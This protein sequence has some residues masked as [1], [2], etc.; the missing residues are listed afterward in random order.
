MVSLPPS[1]PMLTVK[2][3][4]NKFWG[5]M[6]S[7][8]DQSAG[9]V[10]QCKADVL[11]QQILEARVAASKEIAFL[12][13]EILA[14]LNEDINRPRFDSAPV[15]PHDSTNP[16]TQPPPPPPPPSANGIPGQITDPI[17]TP[18]VDPPLPSSS[19]SSSDSRRLLEQLSSFRNET[20]DNFTR[21]QDEL[22][23]LNKLSKQRQQARRLLPSRSKINLRPRRKS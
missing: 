15:A 13:H 17:P 1:R 12:R 6:T 7:M 19:S 3:R 16:T 21:V 9:N 8:K 14:R 2:Y 5:H 18:P 11:S 4:E 20:M 23:K 10:S 22:M